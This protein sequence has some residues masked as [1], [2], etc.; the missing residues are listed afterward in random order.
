MKLLKKM[1]EDL[2]QRRN[3]YYSEQDIGFHRVARADSKHFKVEPRHTTRTPKPTSVERVLSAIDVCLL[4]F[5]TFLT[6]D[7]E[8][9]LVDLQTS[10]CR[11]EVQYRRAPQTCRYCARTTTHMTRGGLRCKEHPRLQDAHLLVKRAVSA[12]AEEI[13]RHSGH[14]RARE[15]LTALLGARGRI[16]PELDYAERLLLESKSER[17]RIKINAFVE[18]IPGRVWDE[19]VRRLQNTRS[20]ELGWGLEAEHEAQKSRLDYDFARGILTQA[21]FLQKSH[22]LACQIAERERNDK[23]FEILARAI[24]GVET[25]ETWWAHPAQAVA[26][27]QVLGDLYEIFSLKPRISPDRLKEA[28][29]AIARGMPQKR[30]AELYRVSPRTL[31]RHQNRSR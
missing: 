31:R 2:C 14:P 27:K 5:S 11:Y 18:G 7:E 10:F 26:R 24:E 4:G 12:C 25:T 13:V 9:L 28:L 29:E 19:M 17:Q 1:T 6:D 20:R 3:K 16:A 23:G 15:V 21:Q 22:Q 30:A 8:T